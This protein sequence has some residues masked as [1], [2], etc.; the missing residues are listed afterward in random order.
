MEM[1]KMYFDQD[2]DL[3]LL[4]GRTVA[5][6][7]FGTQGMAQGLNLRDSG[8]EVIVGEKPGSA[9][10]NKA[11]AENFEVM[12]I[13]EVAGRADI[14]NLQVPDMAFRLADAYNQKIKDKHNDGDLILLS[15]AYN[16]YYDHIQ[17]PAGVDAIVVA[18]KSPGSAVRQEYAQGNGVPG[19]LAVHQ[20]ASGKAHDLGLALCKALGFTRV[21]VQDTTVE[22]ELVTDLMGEHCAWGAIV[23]LLHTVFDV[24]VEAGYNPNI[25]FFEAINESKLTTE[26]I[27]RYGLAGM[28]E[29][30]SNTA[31][32]GAITIGPEIIDDYVKDR[33]RWAMENIKSGAFNQD[34]QADYQS[35]YP[36]FKG[37]LEELRQSEADKV[38]NEIRQHLGVLQKGAL[39]ATNV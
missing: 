8:L 29:R 38:G 18:P 14:F 26:L 7:G 27:Y 32:Y 15:S 17:P 16:Y 21:G 24:L 6:V 34:W 13:E 37:L 23:S 2:A 36:K 4:A 12:P 10:W 19:L 20:D 28:L 33:I 22:E 11:E 5:V 30:I 35:G 39:T 31:A 1:N 25:A 9:A 3:R